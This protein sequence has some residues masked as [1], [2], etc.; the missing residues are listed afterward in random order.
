M[1]QSVY[2][3]MSKVISY[4]FKFLLFK[5]LFPSGHFLF[6]IFVLSF[7]FSLTNLVSGLAISFIFTHKHTNQQGF[8]ILIRTILFSISLISAFIFNIFF[9]G[10][11]FV[12]H[13]PFSRHLNCKF[14]LKK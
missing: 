10:L 3:D 1:F 8:D 12:F 14:K 4:D 13:G 9:L 7:F 11:Y 6:Y 5:S 2:V